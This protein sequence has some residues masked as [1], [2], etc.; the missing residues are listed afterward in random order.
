MIAYVRGVVAEK[1]PARVVL[2]ACGI[3]YEMTIPL[4]TYDRLPA[5]GSE[6]KLFAVHCV[7]EDEESL[8]GF[9]TEAE[10]TMFTLLTGVSGVGPRTAIAILS[11]ISAGE[12]SL[13]VASGDPGRIATVKGVGRKTAEKICVELR[14]KV[15]MAEALAASRAGGAPDAQSAAMRD[16]VLALGALGFSEEAAGKMVARV[17]D[18]APDATDAETLIRLALASK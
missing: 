7:R 3:G 12:L 10:R 9:A 15:S 14:D 6:A 16:A 11:G 18:S 4:S 13:A 2:E 1:E 17:L 8:F 5:A